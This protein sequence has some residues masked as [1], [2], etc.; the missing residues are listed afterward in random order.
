MGGAGSSFETG[1]L[2]TSHEGTGVCFVQSIIS[3]G[4]AYTDDK[5]SCP[6]RHDV[7][8]LAF[9]VALISSCAVGI[10]HEP[11]SSLQSGSG[12]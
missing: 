3:P 7:E 6:S 4:I 11:E 8:N 1:S 2:G 12:G 9:I 10:H 5:E